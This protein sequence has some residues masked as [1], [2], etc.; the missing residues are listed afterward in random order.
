VNSVS[1]YN[2]IAVV[3]FVLPASTGHHPE[4]ST[5]AARLLKRQKGKCAYCG[6]TFKPGDLWEIDHIQ[7]K[8]KGGGN[9]YDNLQLLHKHG[10]DS[11]TSCDGCGASFKSPATEEPDE[12]QCTFRFLRPTSGGTR[13]LSLTLTEEPLCL[14]LLFP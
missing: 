10:P 2:G 5:S 12:A 4:V 11:K 9:G 1:C 14:S 8:A 3:R 7:P 13:M 6:L